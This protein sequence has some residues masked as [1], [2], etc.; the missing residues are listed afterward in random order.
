MLNRNAGACPFT[1]IAVL[2]PSPSQTPGYAIKTPSVSRLIA[3]GLQ[4]FLRRGFGNLLVLGMCALE[5]GPSSRP[6]TCYGAGRRGEDKARPQARSPA[7][8][9]KGGEENM[10]AVITGG[11]RADFTPHE[12]CGV[13]KKKIVPGAF[14][15]R[16]C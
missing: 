14:E 6:E 3:S 7:R 11:S 12:R 2:V 13:L 15:I 9:V 16:N 5:I 4:S 10:S 1:P 8:G